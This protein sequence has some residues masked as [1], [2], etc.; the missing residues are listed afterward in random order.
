MQKKI[1][2]ITEKKILQSCL[3][4]FS[5]NLKLP[6]MR[7]RK[8]VGIKSEAI[9]SL[10]EKRVPKLVYY[11]SS[12]FG[13]PTFPTFNAEWQIQPLEITGRPNRALKCHSMLVLHH[14]HS[15]QNVNTLQ[16]FS[17]R[18]KCNIKWLGTH[19]LQKINRQRGNSPRRFLGERRK[20]L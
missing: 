4:I 3:H 8:N 16:C 1:T 11:H 10:T 13:V 2:L 6:R 17:L 7:Y 5:T 12:N 14:I 18:K 15:R 20:S 9:H 19:S